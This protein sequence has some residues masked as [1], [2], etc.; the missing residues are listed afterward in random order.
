MLGGVNAGGGGASDRVL[1]VFLIVLVLLI[2][3]APLA[4]TELPA[5]PASMNL[6]VLAMLVLVVLAMWVA[7]MVL[8]V[9]EM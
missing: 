8:V 5:R 1:L 7:F 3:P 6:D 9:L 2:T 4:A